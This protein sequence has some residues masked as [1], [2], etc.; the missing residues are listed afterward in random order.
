MENFP[1][2]VGNG[3]TASPTLIKFAYDEPYLGIVVATT[4]GH[5]FMINGKTQCTERLDFGERR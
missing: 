3:V 4:D 2:K 5:L 1:I